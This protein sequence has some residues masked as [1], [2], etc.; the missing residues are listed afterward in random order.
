MK[1]LIP[2]L[3]L[4]CAGAFVGCSTTQTTAKNDKPV[5]KRCEKVKRTGSRFAKMECHGEPPLGLGVINGQE[6]VRRMNATVRPTGNR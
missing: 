5:I 1:A 6:S 2:T 3:A 4:V